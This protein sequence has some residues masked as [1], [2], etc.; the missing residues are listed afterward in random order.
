MP[1]SAKFN[2]QSYNYSKGACPV[3]AI[4]VNGFSPSRI[5]NLINY[6]N[7]INENSEYYLRSTNLDPIY[8]TGNEGDISGY[9]ITYYETNDN[10]SND[11]LITEKVNNNNEPLYY[12]YELKYDAYSI[13][14]DDVLQLYKNNEEL[15]PKNRYTVEYS[16]TTIADNYHGSQ[17]TDFDRYGSGVL[18]E[19]FNGD[20]DVHR[21]RILL[22]I[23]FYN[24]NDFYTIRY[25]KKLYN[26]NYPDHMELLEFKNLYT[27]EL[28]FICSGNYIKYTDISKLPDS[29]ISNLHIIK[30]PASRIES[31]GVYSIQGNTYQDSINTNWNLKINTGSFIKNADRLGYNNDYYAIKYT[32]PD[33]SGIIT[34][35]DRYQYMTNIKPKIIDGNILKVDEKPIYIDTSTY[36]YPNYTIEMFAKTYEDSVVPSGHIS[37]DIDGLN[38]T[39]I[40]ISSIDRDKGYLLL[41]KSIQSSKEIKLHYYTD[42]TEEFYMRNLELNP[43]ISGTYGFHANCEYSFNNIGVAV[44]KYPSN[45]LP[46]ELE[47]RRAYYYPYFFDFDSITSDGSG[48]FYRGS[49][50]SDL[51]G[52]MING[53]LTNNPYNTYSNISGEFMPIYHLS[54]NKL[55][56]DILQIEDARVIG[57]GIDNNDI[58]KLDN[59]QLNSFSDIGYYDGE[60]LPHAS[61][62]I[63]HIPS[64]VYHSYIN[65]WEASDLYNPD[66]YTDVTIDEIRAL[67][68][69]NSGEYM[70]YYNKLLQG[71]SPTTGD[72]V[73]DPFNMMR[74]KWAKKQA[75]HYID[76]LIKKYISA[77]TQYILLDEEFNEIGLDTNV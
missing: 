77:G 5:I 69:N 15:V 68:A 42:T 60:P 36:V 57:G 49:Y 58:S 23:D 67:G 46:A 10:Y 7:D 50:I 63:I 2:K 28:D 73:R 31:P 54:I 9:L 8:Y 62:M 55:T 19:T 74:Y 17:D 44:R 64:G 25:N 30:N 38:K 66:M 6:E 43:R 32:F 53:Y 41:N 56:P 26:I 48:T 11:Y 34:D 21:V 70:E 13:T 61:L 12:T 72:Q 18:W 29:A 40:K 37:I 24:R 47:A 3:A 33:L 20:Y 75:S 65:T 16:T 14:N 45:G 71:I 4:K 22:P 51:S 1:Y 76:Q 52:L 35:Y 27:Q 59:M 39:D